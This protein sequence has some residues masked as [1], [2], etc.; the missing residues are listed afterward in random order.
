MELTQK[1]WIVSI[2]VTKALQKSWDRNKSLYMHR[3]ER[4][5]SYLHC[6]GDFEQ[7]F[8]LS[9]QF[10]LDFTRN[11]FTSRMNAVK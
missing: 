7:I 5:A 6:L 8:D 2:N 3:N 11:L 10:H 4:F 9:E 1:Y